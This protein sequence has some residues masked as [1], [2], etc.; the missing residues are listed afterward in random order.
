[1][2][3]DGLTA[4]L[5]GLATGYRLESIP[6]HL[7]DP[8]ARSVFED[9]LGPYDERSWRLYT[10]QGGTSVV[11]LGAEQVILELGHG[12]WIL[13]QDEGRVYNS[14]PGDQRLGEYTSF[15]L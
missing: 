1:M 11:E 6:V 5:P 10:L 8:D 3:Q 7:D 13:V 2:L 12:F 14:G 15:P 4:A 9:D